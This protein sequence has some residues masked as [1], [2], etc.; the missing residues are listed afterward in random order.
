MR[1]N[2]IELRNL[3]NNKYFDFHTDFCD[4]VIAACP[5]TL[6]IAAQFEYYSAV[7]EKNSKV[8]ID[9]FDN[10]FTGCVQA[11]DRRRD[12]I[13]DGMTDVVRGTLR[14]FCPNVKEAAQRLEV[15]LGSYEYEQ[16]T[17]R[18]SPKEQTVAIENLLEEL[19]GSSANDV[20]T[21]HIGDWVQELATDNKTFEKLVNDCYEYDEK[22]QHT[23]I[24]LRDARRRVDWA[25]H[26][27]VERI[28]A[29]VIIE[30]RDTYDAFIRRVN[31]MITRCIV[32]A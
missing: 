27:I 2:K 6:K 4:V 22:W 25:Y 17:T 7:F 26:S 24:A 1:I 31:L 28:G 14:Y 20:C 15:V 3:R 29:L 12:V 13:F 19:S 23:D 18:R 16:L 5:D 10:I 11:I 30:G 21:V 8:L 9:N 32:S